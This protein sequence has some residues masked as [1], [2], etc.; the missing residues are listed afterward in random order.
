MTLGEKLQ[1][2][3]TAA[4]LT[5]EEAADAVGISRQTLS[6]WENNKSYPDA[7]GIGLLS[8]LYGVSVASVI[9]EDTQKN[10]LSRATGRKWLYQ[11]IQVALYI[12]LWGAMIAVFWL[13][14]NSVH[15][16]FSLM[17]TYGLMPI[18]TVAFGTWLGA[19]ELWKWGKWLFV[20]LGGVTNAMWYGMTYGLANVLSHDKSFSQW[21][22]YAWEP[23]RF[24]IGVGLATAGIVLGIILKHIKRIAVKKHVQQS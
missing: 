9:T 15:V 2:I 17:A 24:W 12:V 11:C 3:R 20:L 23:E 6:N 8:E 19:D 13:G 1:Q 5:Q 4:D 21:L 14:G 10:P 16:L 7:R 22:D 18:L